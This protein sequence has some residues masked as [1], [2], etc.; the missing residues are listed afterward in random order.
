MFHDNAA[1]GRSALRRVPLRSTLTILA[2]LGMASASTCQVNLS[3]E[4]SGATREQAAKTAGL[5][6]YVNAHPYLEKPLKHL[7]KH[8]PELRTLRPAANPDDMLPIILLHAGMRVRS[9]FDNIVDLAAHEEVG[10]KIFTRE[11]SPLGSQQARYSYLILLNGRENP[12]RYEEYRTDVEGHRAE[13]VGVELGYAITTGFALKCIYFSPAMQAG[14][15]FRYLGDE[16]LGERETYVVAFAQRPTQTTFWGTV[17]GEWGTVKILDQGIA[18]IDKRTFQI[19]RIR[20][21]LLAAHQEIGLARQTTE[22]TFGEVQIAEVEKALWL[23]SDA[24]VYAEFQGHT[25]RNEHHYSDYERFRVSV[26]MGSP[27]SYVSS[28]G[29]SSTQ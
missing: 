13:Q 3:N 5:G 29:R 22:V 9:F 15:T 8:V 14:S 18:W 26:K 19:L 7:M 23:P 20:T 28:A 16:M 2:L 17:T 11:G 24:E 1:A 6:Y 12:P 25:F 4:T 10:Q 27:K 21:D